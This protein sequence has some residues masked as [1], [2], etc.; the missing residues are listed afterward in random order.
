MSDLKDRDYVLVID[1]SGSMAEKDCGNGISRFKAAEEATLAVASRLAELDPDGIKVIPFASS[2]R[3]YDNTTP[4]KVKQVFREN[5][6]MGG[7]VLSPVLQEVFSDYLKRKKDGKTKANGELL[8]VVTDGAPQDEADVAPTIVKFANQL[9]NADLEYGIQFLQ[10]G[11]D[12]QAS[13]FLKRLD[14]GLVKEGAKHDIVDTKTM[15]EL[16]NVGLTEAL[17]AALND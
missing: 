4:D 9:D 14:D 6:P 13:A 11:K 3:V 1:K 15:E 2:F 12:G 5:E 16:E 17:L 7:T 10:V 8:V